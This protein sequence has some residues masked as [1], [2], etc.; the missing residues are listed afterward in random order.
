VVG[1]NR[2][3]WVEVVVS[4]GVRM[5]MEWGR[6]GHL[7]MFSKTGGGNKKSELTITAK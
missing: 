5:V 7:R 4:T 6:V 3:E 2:D 1:E